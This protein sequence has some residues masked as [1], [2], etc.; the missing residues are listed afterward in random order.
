MDV[1][2]PVAEAGRPERCL[3]RPVQPVLLPFRHRVRTKDNAYSTIH[4][5][6]LTHPA[7]AVAPTPRRHLPPESRWLA[8]VMILPADSRHQAVLGFG[9]YVPLPPVGRRQHAMSAPVPANRWDRLSPTTGTCRSHRPLADATGPIP[10]GRAP[11]VPGGR[12]CARRRVPLCRRHCSSLSF[13]RHSFDQARR[14]FTRNRALL[15]DVPIQR[16]PHW[17]GW[18]PPRARGSDAALKGNNQEAFPDPARGA[19]T[20][21]S[22]GRPDARGGLHGPNLWPEGLPDFRDAMTGLVV[23]DG[24]SLQGPAARFSRWGSGCRK[25]RSCA[26]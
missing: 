11:P 16:S 4:T 24:G 9:V 1:L 15:E 6:A 14:L 3:F 18:L 26:H 23:A 10:V 17:R 7:R 2:V 21:G 25:T 20:S 12:G 19:G 13:G 5:R 8:Q 22:S